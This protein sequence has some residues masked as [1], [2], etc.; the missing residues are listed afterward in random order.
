M[1]MEKYINRYINDVKEN[2][3]ILDVGTGSGRDMIFGQSLGYNFFG[4]DNC[5]GFIELLSKHASEGLINENSFKHCDMR[6]LDFPNNTFDVVRHNAS[7]LHLPLIGKNYTLDLALSEAN[8]VL[9]Q[10]GLLYIL[11]KFGNGLEVHDTGEKLGGRIF[12]FFNHRTLNEVVTR[13]DFTI[14]FTSDLVELR[15]DTIIDWILLI[16]QKNS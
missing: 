6:L 11:V 3:S 2:V 7:L 4:V 14:L 8:R 5:E 10:R 1:K 16:A 9:K 13:N 12:Q 15:G